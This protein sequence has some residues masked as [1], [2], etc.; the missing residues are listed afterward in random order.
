MHQ[1]GA[2]ASM[3]TAPPSSCTTTDEVMAM[4]PHHRVRSLESLGR[5]PARSRRVSRRP[6]GRACRCSAVTRSPAVKQHCG[7]APDL[8]GVEESTAPL[9][10]TP[11]C[12]SGNCWGGEVSGTQGTQGTQGTHSKLVSPAKTS[13]WREYFSGID[14][15]PCFH[16]FRHID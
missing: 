11:A 14:L 2:C 1:H 8:T 7:I 16:L 12:R 6:G 10:C 5:S 13:R 4:T 3:C 15:H 9:R